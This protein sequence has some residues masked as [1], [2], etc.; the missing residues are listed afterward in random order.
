MNR[1]RD[2]PAIARPGLV[3]FGSESMS[4]ETRDL[5]ESPSS[6]DRRDGVL[7]LL[8][9]MALTAM[10]AGMGWGIRGQY[11]HES[12]AMIAGALASLTLILLFVP[13][14]PSLQ[15]ARAAA[16]MT[17]AV[18]IGGSMTYGQTVGLTHDA[19]LIGNQA[20]LRWGML[21]LFV[22]GGLWIGF[23]GVFL[24]MGLSGKKY[25]PW[26]MGLLMPALVGLMILGVW[27]INMPFDPATRSLPRIYF[28]DD[29]YFEPDGDLKPRREIWGGYLIALAGLLMYVRLVRGD[30]LAGRMGLV[31]V[32][33]GGLGFPGGQCVQAFHAWHPSVFTEGVLA[34]GA[35][36]FRHFNWWNM[37]ETTFGL[38]WGA[39]MAFGLWLNRHLIGTA[40][41][42]EPV[43]IGPFRE[44]LLCVLHVVLLLSA[45]FLDLPGRIGVFVG[46]YVEL[47]LLMAALPVIAIVGGRYW[48]YLVLLPIVVAPIAGKTLRTVCYRETLIPV[49]VGWFAL[50][51]IPMAVAVCGAVWLICGSLRDQPA[52]RFAAVALLL[53]TWLFY[54]LNTVVFEFAWPWKALGEWTVRTP[55]QLIFS[56]CAVSLTLAAMWLGPR[57]TGRTL[58]GPIE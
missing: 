27:L 7:F 37:M 26:E 47:G 44:T 45:T 58:T 43:S 24:G 31:G 2:R 40:G 10:A 23:A 36:Y 9:A 32:I 46:L 50:V 49:D 18:G 4:V 15:S 29:W 22:K 41:E 5:P 13:G 53:T 48:P 17:V 1:S 20:A 38:I 42:A 54:G 55:N 57:R 6:R 19:E 25:R 16:L 51:E 34:G 52:N 3:L 8:C 12:G 11:G 39:V 14:A 28:S 21:G 30:R 33:A 56:V 35:E